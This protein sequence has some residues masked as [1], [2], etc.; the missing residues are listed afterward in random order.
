MTPFLQRTVLIL[1]GTSVLGA[2]ATTAH[3]EM[4]KPSYP[5]RLPAAETA[6]LQ[7]A[8]SQGEPR[9]QL[10]L[11]ASHR[12]SH[13]APKGPPATVKVRKGDSLDAIADRLGVTVEQL[14]AA[15]GLKRNTIQPGD[16]LKNPKAKTA[17][18]SA[19]A[20]RKG[21]KAVSR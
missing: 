12:R 5:I 1:L 8:V 14:K 11:A 10:I 19:S 20:G 9:P 16:I 2:G 17:K 6:T 13:A 21:A 15:N 3:A 7:P 4:F 18:A